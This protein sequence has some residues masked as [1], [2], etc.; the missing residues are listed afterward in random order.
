M[1]ETLRTRQM[2][3]A[4]GGTGGGGY[5]SYRSQRSGAIAR[6]EGDS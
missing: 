3:A 1:G 6:V 4:L 5:A 2:G